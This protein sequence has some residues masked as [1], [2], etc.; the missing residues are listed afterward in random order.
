MVY[1]I[2]KRIIPPIIKKLWVKEVNGLENLPKEGPYI[3]AANHA[4]YMDHFVISLLVKYLNKKMPVVLVEGNAFETVAEAVNQPQSI[5]EFPQG[6]SF[7][8]SLS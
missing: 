6:F 4:S 1:P 7:L 5:G 2:G 8:K 3:I